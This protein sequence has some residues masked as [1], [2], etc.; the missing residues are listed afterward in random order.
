V[1]RQSNGRAP[2]VL[3]GPRGTNEDYVGSFAENLYDGRLAATVDLM[4]LHRQD[5]RT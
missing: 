5:S 3:H 1:C 2:R 4:C